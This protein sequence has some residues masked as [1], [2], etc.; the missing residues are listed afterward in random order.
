MPEKKTKENKRNME[1]LVQTAN[2]LLHCNQLAAAIKNFKL[3]QQIVAG[4]QLLLF[5]SLST[6]PPLPAT[7]KWEICSEFIAVIHFKFHCRRTQI[8]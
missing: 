3:C 6:S 8:N 4:R 1:L 5:L 2:L 7:V